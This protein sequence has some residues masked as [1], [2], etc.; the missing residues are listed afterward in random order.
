[1]VLGASVSSISGELIILAVFGAV[2]LSI[3]VPAFKRAM[4]R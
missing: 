3:A 1:M 4:T 2:L